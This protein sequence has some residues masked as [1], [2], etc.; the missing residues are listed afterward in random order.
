MKRLLKSVL[1]LLLMLTI[2]ACGNGDI[3]N[4]IPPDPEE[5]SKNAESLSAEELFGEDVIIAEIK[6]DTQHQTMLGFGASYTWYSDLALKFPEMRDEIADL[7][8][9]DAKMTILRFKNDYESSV[10][11]VSEA[12]K[13]VQFFSL[14][15][16]RAAEYGEDVIVL[17]SSW[18]PPPRLKSNDSINGRDSVTGDGT[19]K[20]NEFGNYMYDEFARWWADS[21]EAYRGA[22]LAVD[23]ISIQNEC[24]FPA[25]YDGMMLA[26]FEN[27]NQAEYA[28]AFLATY[29]EMQNR[30]NDNAPLMLGPETMTFN[31]M[32]LKDYMKNITDTLPEAV[33]GIAFHLYIGG[34]STGEWGEG[35]NPGQSINEPNSFNRNFIDNYFEF[36]DKF[37]LWQTEFYRGTPMQTALLMNNAL[38][39]GNVSAYLHWAGIWER[40]FPTHDLIGVNRRGEYSVG[41]SYYVMR[42]FSEFIRPGYIRVQVSVPFSYDYSI[43]AFKS[44]D[45]TKLAIVLINPTHEDMRIAIPIE[46]YNI[47]DS[48]IYQTVLEADSY[49]ADN[50]Y[51]DIGN[52]G[53]S[54]TVL[55]K[56]YS[57][58]TIDIN[59]GRHYG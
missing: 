58:T 29:Y 2:V 45:E 25:A 22:G 48:V 10:A 23:Y 5:E 39:N 8:F 41:S 53:Q 18:S 35:L 46:G 9:K 51:A 20:K 37:P 24:D 30:F 11:S 13:E 14:A 6:L 52:L 50:Y 32:D 21:I 31:S 15:R 40:D 27:E 57:I 55:L 28:R 7:L 38:V 1:Y 49:E 56:A 16:E 59:G 42:H 17:L 3:T 44:P 34:N 4:N 43:S 36:K 54:N 12:A 47:N 19:L 26:K 33:A